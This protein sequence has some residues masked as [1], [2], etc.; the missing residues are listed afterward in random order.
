MF[1][2]I[3]L[4]SLTSLTTRGAGPD[5]ALINLGVVVNDR[6]Q[7][8]YS[9]TT[10]LWGGAGLF[11]DPGSS[12]PL[13][14]ADLDGGAEINGYPR[15]VANNCRSPWIVGP[16]E[17]K[18]SDHVS[19]LLA[20]TNL[21]DD[22]SFIRNQEIGVVET[23]F[24]NFYY[25]WM[26]GNIVVAAGVAG[27][28]GFVEG[29]K[30]WL[31]EVVR[32]FLDDPVGFILGVEVPGRCNGPIFYTVVQRTGRELAAL[33]YAASRPV[34]PTQVAYGY[35]RSA[36]ISPGLLTDA[37]THPSECGAIARTECVFEIQQLDR[38]SLNAWGLKERRH[39]PGLLQY[40]REKDKLPTTL[41][42]LAGLIN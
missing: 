37:E 7:G 2:R 15:P 4:K 29:L 31:P 33:D 10:P 41:R 42:A 22:E 25:S 27:A 26:L 3:G 32:E 12:V 16:I 35:R 18:D 30:G 8:S 36:F 6:E 13:S 38:Y 19:I 24:L 9:V 1:Y 11:G 34:W 23:K 40:A 39:A 20:G 5:I 14:G 21:A 28:M 17:I